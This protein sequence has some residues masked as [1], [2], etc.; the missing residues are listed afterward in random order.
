MLKKVLIPKSKKVIFIITSV[1]AVVLL[2]VVASY[3]LPQIV[4][5]ETH[6]TSSKKFQGFI[7]AQEIEVS[8]QDILKHKTRPVRLKIIRKLDVDEYDEIK[9]VGKYDYLSWSYYEALITYDFSKNKT[10]D[11]SIIIS[12]FGNEEW[13][14]KGDP[15]LGID[16]EYVMFLIQNKKTDGYWGAYL[17]KESVYDIVKEKDGEFLYK[18]GI[19]LPIPNNEKYYKM[20]KKDVVTTNPEN[21]VAYSQK[22]TKTDLV[23]LLK[24]QK[25]S[26]DVK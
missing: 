20:D 6:A 10:L 23:A 7:E 4:D 9:G 17:G 14:M 25:N 15:L 5:N 2:L 21:P 12:Q 11:E 8:A 19:A 16:Q 26:T 1:V 24:D 13:Q 18:R 3:F 22:I